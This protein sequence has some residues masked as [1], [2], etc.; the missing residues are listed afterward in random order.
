[1][2][3]KGMGHARGNEL[4]WRCVMTWKMPTPEQWMQYGFVALF[5]VGTVCTFILVL[6]LL[7]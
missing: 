1:M 3:A 4:Q 7:K 5:V 2:A 6:A